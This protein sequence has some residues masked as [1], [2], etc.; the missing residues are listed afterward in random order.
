MAPIAVTPTK[1]LT[2]THVKGLLSVDL[3]ERATRVVRPVIHELN[4]TSCDLSCQTLDFWSWLEKKAASADDGALDDVDIGR[5]YVRFHQQA[6]ADRPPADAELIERVERGFIHPVSARLIEI[7]QAQYALLGIRDPG[8]TRARP[9]PLSRD[10]VFERL[11]AADLL[12]DQREFAGHPYLDL[13]DGGLPLR[14]LV[15]PLGRDNYLL[16]LLRELFARAG[17]DEDLALMCDR[18]LDS[19]YRLLETSLRKC[20]LSAFWLS[21]PRVSLPGVGL[22]SA[23]HGGW[24][25]YTVSRLAERCIPEYG[26]AAFRLGIRLYLLVAQGPGCKEPF[27][28]EL[29]QRFIKRARRLLDAPLTASREAGAEQLRKLCDVRGFAEPYRVASALISP[30]LS[31]DLRPWIPDLFL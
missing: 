18:E 22:G 26:E 1:P 6:A 19:D 5:L 13:T 31:E 20:G 15:D 27:R 21:M 10:A 28:L 23:R 16:S 12:L 14:S 11:S 25:D 29:L 7:W 4:R 24:E 17:A 30:H 8:L 2:P 3:M 9:L